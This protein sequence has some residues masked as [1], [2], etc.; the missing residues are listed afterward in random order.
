MDKIHTIDIFIDKNI[1][2]IP[3]VDSKIES[4]DGENQLLYLENN[5]VIDLKE[6]DG[7]FMEII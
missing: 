2:N 3:F 5:K 6:S 1:N 4:V 7:L